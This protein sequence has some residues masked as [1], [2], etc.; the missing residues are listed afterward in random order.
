[1]QECHAATLRAIIA[2]RC[3]QHIVRHL[4]WVLPFFSRW[5][6]EY[7]GPYGCIFLAPALSV[8]VHSNS[9]SK[10]SMITRPN[11][12]AGADRA[13]GSDDAADWLKFAARNEKSAMLVVLS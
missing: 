2:L 12:A 13:R 6:A 9:S 5:S 7:C 10:S 4:S 8:Y 1:M 11:N 3:A